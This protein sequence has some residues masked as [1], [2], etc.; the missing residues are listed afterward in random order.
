[1]PQEKSVFPLL[2][3]FG[4]NHFPGSNY[5][6]YAPNDGSKDWSNDGSNM[7]N[8][9]TKRNKA[10]GIKKQIQFL[11]QGLTMI[12]LSGKSLFSCYK[13]ITKRFS[14]HV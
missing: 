7:K 14:K 4:F 11:L 13:K 6:L 3:I 12:L 10:I 8:I 5:I 2:G 9:E 1:M